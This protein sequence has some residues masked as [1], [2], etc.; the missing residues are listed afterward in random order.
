MRRTLLI[1]VTA[2]LVAWAASPAHAAGPSVTLAACTT[3]ATPL[4][5]SARFTATMAARKGTHRMAMRFDLL[6]R[7]AD[8]GGFRRL[9]AAGFGTW[10]RSRRGVPA[11]VFTK[12]V[13]GLAPRASYRA[14]VRFR[15]HDARGRIVRR[16]QRRSAICDQPDP[17]PDLVVGNVSAAPASDADRARY[18]VTVRNTGRGDAAVPFAVVLTV[19][20]RPQP[21]QTIATLGAG[22]DAVV[23]FVAPRCAPGSRIGIDVDADGAIEET[24]EDNNAV[25]RPC[26]S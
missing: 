5:R 24:R 14:V 9:K 13:A 22:G 6:E 3:G 10:E 26:P 15:W 8:L 4:D 16:A 21:A 23:S 2:L 25:A 7:R 19:D 18:V 17:R 12:R 1:A 11:F 20:G